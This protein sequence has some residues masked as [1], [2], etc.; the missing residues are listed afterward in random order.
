MHRAAFNQHEAMLRASI[1]MISITKQAFAVG[2]YTVSPMI[3][4]NET[5][6][7]TALVSIRNGSHDRV[8]RFTPQFSSQHEAVQYAIDEAHLWLGQRV[9]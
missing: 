1:N 2:K 4:T 6:R 9:S 5:G 3:R 7:F 8:F